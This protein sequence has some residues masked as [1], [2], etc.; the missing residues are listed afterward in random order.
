M[1]GH[2]LSN[3]RASDD[4]SI[5][6]ADLA[7]L[8]VVTRVTG[9]GVTST[10]AIVDGTVY[11]ADFAGHLKA[12]NAT[13]GAVVWDALVQRAQDVGAFPPML[14]PSP[15]VSTD[16]VYIA[17]N[18]GW[19]YAVN[20]ADGTVRWRKQIESTIYSRVSSSP[21]VVGNTLV[22]GSGSYQVFIPVMQPADQIFH[23]SIKGLDA[24]TGDVL[25][26]TTVC[27]PASCGSGV[28]VWSS[29]AIDPSLKLAYIGTGQTYSAPAG[30]M[31]DSLVAVDY[32]TGAISWS[33]QFTM[34]DIYNIDT[35]PGSPNGK[36]QDVGAAPNLFTA[37]VNG[38]SRQL[39][40][41]GDKGGRY[42][43]FDRTT[44][45][46]IWSVDFKFGSPIG[47][48]MHSPAYANGF[49]YVVNNTSDQ[50]TGRN[51]AIP[52][53][54]TIN[55]VNAATGAIAWQTP[56]PAGGFGGVSIANGLMYFMTWD[57]QLRVVDTANGKLLK[58]IPVSTMVGTY[59]PPPTDA[60]PDGSASGPVVVN[61]RV[62]VGFGW[63]WKAAVTGGLAILATGTGSSA[64]DGGAE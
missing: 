54:S 49:I 8:H 23:G 28:S 42:K 16:T 51:D 4:R 21:V 11:Y 7:S 32:E 56:L 9:G 25:W 13:T 44:G 29:A 24:A 41:V 26:S 39:V 22:I 5:S 58:S 45:E 15:F 34:G 35:P 62:Y 2:D 31:S 52:G 14:S 33:K 20:R 19:V 18:V 3:T 6:A 64:L 53:S 27:P 30:P 43:A 12:V 60:F 63:T 61:G 10:P 48:V 38:T 17:G 55:A 57:G 40:G 47:G 1:F 46:L 59:V 50:G 36:D 37:T